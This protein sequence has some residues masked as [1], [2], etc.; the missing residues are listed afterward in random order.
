MARKEQMRM[1]VRTV[2]SVKSYRFIALLDPIS[3]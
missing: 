1:I 3:L 2:N